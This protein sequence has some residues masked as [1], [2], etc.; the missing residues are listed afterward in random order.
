MPPLSLSKIFI[1]ILGILALA[2]LKE[3]FSALAPVG[4]WFRD[5]LFGMYNY[6]AGAQTAIAFLSIVLVVA[7]I[8]KHFANK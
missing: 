5:S 4:W 6:P 8:V 7:L 2:H 1:A 3:I